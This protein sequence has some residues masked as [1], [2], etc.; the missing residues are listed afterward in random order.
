MISIPDKA[1]GDILIAAK[2]ETCKNYS[3]LNRH[4]LKKRGHLAPKNLDADASHDYSPATGSTGLRKRTM[5]RKMPRLNTKPIVT[6]LLERH[7]LDAY[8]FLT[9][10]ARKNAF[11]LT[12]RTN[13]KHGFPHPH[14]RPH[15]TRCKTPKLD[16]TT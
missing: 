15:K 12:D 9:L 1:N 4:R 10:I 3:A 11:S 5:C 8:H 13:G 14:L 7:A 6:Q 2:Y 16:L